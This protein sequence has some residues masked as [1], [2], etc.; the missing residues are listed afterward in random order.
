MRFRTIFSVFAAVLLISCQSDE[1]TNLTLAKDEVKAYY[2][3]GFYG[4]ETYDV[5]EKAMN[6]L[7][8]ENLTSNAMVVFDVD[9]T[10]LSNYS[11]IESVD[12]GWVKPLWD[13]WILSAKAKN[14]P[15][16]KK[17]YDYL[18]ENS[19][20]VAFLTG[21]YSDHYEAT[22][23]NLKSEGFNTFDTLICRGVKDSK[24]SAAL[25]K[26]QKRKMLVDKGFNIVMCVGDQWTD[27]E[28][29]N[30]G[31]KVKLPNYLYKIK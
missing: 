17:L 27:L 9:E 19:I 28:G 22:L 20:N 13:E 5:I 23:K 10:V 14:I 29:D 4:K 8:K 31:I 12:F 30:T 1:I 16:V 7:K 11:H 6:D 26:K 18:V 3:D 15:Q 2:K 25:Y 24:M 21:R